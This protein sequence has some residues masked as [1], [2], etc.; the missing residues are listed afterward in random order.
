MHWITD[1]CDYALG[2]DRQHTICKQEQLQE[3]MHATL[4]GLAWASN[5]LVSV[6]YSFGLG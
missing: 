3:S 4:V 5:R 1:F 6:T 2:V